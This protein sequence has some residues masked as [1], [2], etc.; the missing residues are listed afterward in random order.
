MSTREW[1]E[2]LVRRLIEQYDGADP[3]EIMEQYADRL[4]ADAFQDALPVRPDL[5]ATVKGIRRHPGD[6]DFAGRIYADEDGQ[7]FMDVNENDID[8]RQHFTEAHELMHTAFPGFTEEGRYRRESVAMERHPPNREEEYLCDYGAAA[9]LMPASLVRDAYSVR[10]GLGDVERL[11]TDAEVSVEAAAN[12][13][14]A[15]ADEPAI[16]LCLAK[17]HKPAERSALRRGDDV[18]MRLRVRYASTSPHLG[19]YVPRFKGA[20]DDSVFCRA[21]TDWRAQSGIEPL[22]GAE[23]AGRFRIEAKRYGAGAHERVLAIGRPTA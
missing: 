18:P 7:L 10:G 2:P 3:E 11:S 22:P 12:R 19:V 17:M 8:E 9:L 15:L 20:E 16:L 1:S 6:F 13:L 14:V 21:A 5:I 23:R 4:R